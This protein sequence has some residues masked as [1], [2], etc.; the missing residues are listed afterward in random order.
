MAPVHGSLD[1]LRTP[2]E[3]YLIV[4]GR[5]WRASDPGLP[6]EQRRRL[7]A[8]LMAARRD[9][10]LARRQGD[11]ESLIRARQRVDRAKTA[12]GERGPVWWTDGSPDYNRRLVRHTPYCEWFERIQ[13]FADAI[14]TLLAARADD[15]SICPSEVARAVVPTNWR[16]HLDDVRQAGRQLARHGAIVILQRGRELDPDKP[17]RGP[18]RYRRTP[19]VHR[20]A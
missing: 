17:V 18:I 12:L 20:R 1:S 2:D 4:R 16:A 10:G 14:V 7:T 8:R 6:V 13:A 5:L 11:R 15:A 19:P 3:R 9:V